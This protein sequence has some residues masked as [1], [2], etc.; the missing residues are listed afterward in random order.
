MRRAARNT[1]DTR[2]VIKF[3]WVQQKGAW[4]RTIQ[5]R[6]TVRGF[7]DSGKFDV[8]R[9]AGTSSR[10]SQ[11]V[12]VSEAAARGSDILSADIS[13]AFLQGVTYKELAELTGEAPREINFY[14]PAADIPL[15]RSLPG[16]EDFDPARE[17]LH[18]DRP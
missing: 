10:S 14:L 16:Y 15:L 2:W 11:K 12:V 17:V 5:A 3:K 1:I 18:C 13:K 8:D 4:V 7:K 6:L 9:Y